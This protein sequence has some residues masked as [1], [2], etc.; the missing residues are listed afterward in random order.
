MKVLLDTNVVFDV[1][2][3]RQPHYAAS[4]QVMKLARR[5]EFLAAVASHSVAN[6]FYVYGR[7][8]TS[9]LCER[10][11]DDVEVCCADAH[12]TRWCLRLGLPDL[13]D[14][15]QAGAAMAWK[16]QFI[17]TRNTRDF[18][19][20]TIPAITPGDFLHRFFRTAL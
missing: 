14:A 6:G 13:E 20:S 4:N 3:H 18:R 16:A 19:Q 5:G 17:I 2:E 15:L 7:P 10:F 9:F 12:L 1:Y 11:L 8:F